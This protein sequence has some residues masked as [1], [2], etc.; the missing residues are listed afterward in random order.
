MVPDHLLDQARTLLQESHSTK[1]DA[2]CAVWGDKLSRYFVIVIS[3]FGMALCL[4]G[5]M[6]GNPYALI[7]VIIC[8]ALIVASLW[9]RNRES[10]V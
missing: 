3:A 9:R 2:D 4:L 6:W 7:G 8:G 1:F 10:D 5:L